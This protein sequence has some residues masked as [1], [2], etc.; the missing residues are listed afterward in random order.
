MLAKLI[1]GALVASAVCVPIQSSAEPAT[2]A[3]STLEEVVV[4]AHPS[5]ASESHLAQPIIVL[6]GDELRKKITSSIGET[7]SR[8][9]G[10]SSTAFGAGA[11][12]PVIRGLSGSRVR[13]LEGGVSSM[14]VSNLSP[15][16]AVSI[17]P[18][19]ATQIE[20]IKGP[21]TLLYGSGAIGGVVNVVT[22]RIAS[23]LPPDFTAQSE[24]SYGTGSDERS[25]A[26]TADGALGQV[27]LHLDGSA[28]DT[29]NYD[30]P[31]FGSTEPEPG[32]S[33]GSLGSSDL[34]T[35]SMTGGASYIGTNGYLG[36]DIGHF[37]TN[38]GVPGEGA[39]IDLGQLRYDI[40]AEI[41]EP[42]SQIEKLKVQLGHVDYEHREFEPNG[43][44]GTTFKNDEYDGRLEF[45]HHPM[46]QWR[47]TLG[48]QIGYRDFA[49]IGDES[50]TPPLASHSES[51][52]LV[53]ERDIGSWH[54]E[55]G[56]RLEQ[57]SVDP[58]DDTPDSYHFVYS[59][60]GGVIANFDDE[61]SVG[62]YLSR[63]QRA[64][65]LEELYNNGPHEAT[66]TFELGSRAL[67][68]ESANNIDI[69]FRALGNDWPWKFNLYAN[70]IEDFIFTD[71]VDS[72]N[73]GKA[74]RV[75]DEGLP[76]IDLDSLLLIQYAQRDAVFYGIEAETTKH[77]IQS[78]WGDVDGRLS[79]D[80]VRGEL[81][82]GDNLPRITP[83]RLGAGLDFNRNRWL[84]S[85]DVFRVARQH[86]NAELET[87]TDGYTLLSMNVSY[88]LPIETVDYVM[89]LRGSNLLDEEAR[90][91]T[92]F[93]KDVAPLPGRS[94]LLTFRAQY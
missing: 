1:A 32:D 15:D 3:H 28:R 51:V 43:E 41:E 87:E 60:S 16:H 62:M 34:E 65:S 89:S 10:V 72:D 58:K 76:T 2:E 21:A 44:L 26:F 35:Q 17:E 8:E 78:S 6:K 12:R 48:V 59:V 38:Y 52:F 82:N 81:T 84:A 33:R 92:S 77:L 22:N 53:E 93:L 14:D 40:K 73:D 50:L 18:L 42:L 27:A 23:E 70:Y 63:A 54:L 13:L 19:A 61:Y 69:T 55:I 11:S 5:D 94:V 90:T 57:Q 49:A 9:L 75:D 7:L 71:N 80:Y 45:L 74:D 24:V 20:V 39:R 68:E 30:I 31:G 46:A 47:G 91:H 64:P 86:D 83:L 36:F 67:T 37:A 79:F 4:T 85:I 88:K 29:H 25:G 56:G 66:G